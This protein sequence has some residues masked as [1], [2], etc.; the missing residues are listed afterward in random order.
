ML[1][2]NFSSK[3]LEDAVEQ[4]GS[5]PGVGRKSALRLALH[6]LKQPSGDV[7]RFARSLVRLRDEVK[8]CTKCGMIS[9]TDICPVCADRSRDRSIVCVVESIRD[10]L[11]IESTGKYRGVYHVL[12]GIISPIDGVG[13]SDI[14]IRELVERVSAQDG[15][16]VR[17]VILA[18][19]TNVEGET[20]SFYIYRQLQPSGVKMTSIA[21]GVG[22]GDD[23]E[24]TD[25]MTLARSIEDRREFISQK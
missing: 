5:L 3:L 12:G 9:D 7:H 24:Y 22:F 8:Y 6:F 19:N 4:I 16:R 17:E 1:R 13:P 25:E 21:R 23:L 11:S 20:T 10:V 15:D 14:R 18:L 2:Q